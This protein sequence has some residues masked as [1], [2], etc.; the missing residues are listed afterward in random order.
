MGDNIED[1]D[2]EKEQKNYKIEI[3]GNNIGLPDCK[4]NEEMN[5][6]EVNRVSSKKVEKTMDVLNI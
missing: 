6:L 3:L 2:I 5:R 4:I 1:M